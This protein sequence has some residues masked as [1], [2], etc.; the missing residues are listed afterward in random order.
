MIQ[1]ALQRL[2]DGHD[3]TLVTAGLSAIT[4]ITGFV[5]FA[6][7]NEMSPAARFSGGWSLVVCWGV[8]GGLLAAWAFGP[9]FG[10]E[11]LWIW[12]RN[13]NTRWSD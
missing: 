5:V 3:L 12:N 13:Y 4:L 1:K 8:T 7:M 10:R 6:N 9:G 11:I 2:L